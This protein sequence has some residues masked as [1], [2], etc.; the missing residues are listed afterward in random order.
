M[1]K[2]VK[3]KKSKSKV[4]KKTVVTTAAK[5]KTPTQPTSEELIK[6][7]DTRL[8][9]FELELPRLRTAL[10]D[11]QKV[12][13]GPFW[14]SHQGVPV[15]LSSMDNEHLVNALRICTRLDARY[16]FDRE[17]F[18]SFLGM[19]QEAKRRN[20]SVSQWWENAR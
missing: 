19:M 3:K 1:K 14:R 7:L 11:A 10:C 5:K 8:R 6:Q 16:S 18:K 20:I 9:L 15:P 12:A 2:V 13:A 4:K 17:R